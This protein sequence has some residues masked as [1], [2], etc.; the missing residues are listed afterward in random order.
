MLH[1]HAILT[2]IF[3]VKLGLAG[4]CL[5]LQS[6]HSYHRHLRRTGQ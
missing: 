6:H 2:G 3:Q 1:A 5:D 4:C